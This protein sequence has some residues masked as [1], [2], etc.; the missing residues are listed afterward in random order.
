MMMGPI[1]CGKTTLCQRLAGLPRIYV[2][3]QTAGIIGKAID[4]PGEYTENRSLRNRLVVTAVDAGL[5]LFLQ[6]AANRGFCFSPGQAAMFS[7]PVAGVITKTDLAGKDDIRRAK[8]L[9]ALAGAAP[10][11]AVSSLTGEG[12]AELTAYINSLT[13][14]NR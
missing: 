7:S 12:V 4:T 13:N 9:L 14:G 10:V 3:T 11:F 2:K 5:V 1:S 6:D 8:D